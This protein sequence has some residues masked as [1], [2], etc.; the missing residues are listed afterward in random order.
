MQ[1]IIIHSIEK[2]PV[3]ISGCGDDK[4]IHGY[5][6]QMN[7]EDS[8]GIKRFVNLFFDYEGKRIYMIDPQNKIKLTFKDEDYPVEKC[9]IDQ[10]IDVI[11]DKIVGPCNTAAILVCK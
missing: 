3:I 2:T 7:I 5:Y 10:Q 9:Q 4:A 11:V 6:Y 1:Q 8:D